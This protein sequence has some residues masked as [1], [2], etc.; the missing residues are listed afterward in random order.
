VPLLLSDLETFVAGLGLGA[1]VNLNRLPDTPDSIIVASTAPGG[2]VLYDGAFEVVHVQYRIRGGPNDDAAAETL[3]LA[4]HQALV[5]HESSFQMGSTYVLSIQPLS[6]P[7]YA[8]RDVDLRTV[9]VSTY[10]FT[11]PA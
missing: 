9:Y 6:S 5:A 3:A 4:L 10:Q 8:G 11:V 1:P 7:T 2:A